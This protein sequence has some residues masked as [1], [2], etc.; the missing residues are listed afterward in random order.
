M[1]GKEAIYMNHKGQ[2][3]FILTRTGILT[4]LLVIL[5]TATAPLG[6]T[7]VTGSLVNCVLIVS[8]LSCGL[9]AGLAVALL[10]PVMAKLVGIGPLWSLIPFIAAGN[11]VLA[12]VWHFTAGK[13]RGNVHAARAAAIVAGAAAKFAVLYLGIVRL[14]VPHLLKLPAPQAAVVSGMFS[15][16]QLVTAV[17]G[18]VL[19]LPVTA[20]VR[21]LRAE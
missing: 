17:V 14:A 11:G 4:A 19:A 8:V 9:P 7:L 15:L 12:A 16:P 20:A 21:G 6:N 5:Q 18:G 10:S 13:S 3:I 2:K 1:Q